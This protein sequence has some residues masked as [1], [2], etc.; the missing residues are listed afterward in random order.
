MPGCLSEL[1]KIRVV[2][3]QQAGE[4][5]GVKSLPRG[6]QP[7]SGVGV[8]TLAPCRCFPLSR[9]PGWTGRVGRTGGGAAAGQ[10]LARQGEHPFT[11]FC[12]P[13]TFSPVLGM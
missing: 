3:K 8:R 1:G 5:Q 12:L 11:A 6:V 13:V 4:G 10:Q 2:E 9:H 7:V